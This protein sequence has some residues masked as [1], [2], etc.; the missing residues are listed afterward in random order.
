MS[1]WY[2]TSVRYGVSLG[3]GAGVRSARRRGHTGLLSRHD[4]ILAFGLHARGCAMCADI[5]EEIG[6]FSCFIEL[7][8]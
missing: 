4:V 1:V 7:F 6:S 5:V 3:T 2:T 8:V